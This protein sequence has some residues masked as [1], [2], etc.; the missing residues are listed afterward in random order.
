[1]KRMLTLAC[2][3]VTVLSMTTVVLSREKKTK[4]GPLSGTWE[5]ATH[6][7]PRGNSTFTLTLEQTGED[8]TGSLVSPQGSTEISG[9]YRKKLLEIQIDAGN[10]TYTLTGKLNK[11]QISGDYSYKTEDGDSSSGTWDGKRTTE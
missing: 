4:L 7:G 10:G 3:F 2:A 8:V 5:C 9:T 1:M 6:G 11:N